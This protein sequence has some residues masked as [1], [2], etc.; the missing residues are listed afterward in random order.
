MI[1]FVHEQA[2]GTSDP[3]AAKVLSVC[4][5]LDYF[6]QIHP[7]FYRLAQLCLVWQ[8]SQHEWLGDIAI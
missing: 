7:D 8:G 5:T 4:V 1:H 6:Q 3:D 2:E